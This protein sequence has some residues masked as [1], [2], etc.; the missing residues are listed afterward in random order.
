MGR[1]ITP[2]HVTD[3]ITGEKMPVACGKCPECFTRRTS[4]WSFRLMQQDKVSNCSHFIT[5]TYDTDYVPIS[6]NGFLTLSKG[7]QSDLTKFFKRLRKAHD[8]LYK[9]LRV[10]VEDRR[11]IRY[12]ACGEYGTK[13][14]R[15]HYHVLIFD[16]FIELIQKA[17]TDPETQK[18]IGQVHYGTVTEASCGYTLKYMCKPG[19][20]P[21][22]SRD[23]RQKEFSVMSKGLGLNYLSERMRAWHINDLEGRQYCPLPDGKKIAMPRYYRDKLYTEQQKK[24]LQFFASLKELELNPMNSRDLAE[25]H[26]AAFKR[27]YHRAVENRHK[28]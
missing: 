13:T 16:C 22:H 5:L 23:D 19:K 21:L 10:P 3:K 14:Q 1:C 17:W 8:S 2:F 18:P 26:I 11:K 25:A 4:G 9:K 27:F 7:R 28:V 12:Y 24:R 15:P 6:K 20:I